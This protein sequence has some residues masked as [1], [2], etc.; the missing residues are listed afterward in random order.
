[1]VDATRSPPPGRELAAPGRDGR[2]VVRLDASTPFSRREAHAQA[3]GVK[4]P[5]PA[6]E[7]PGRARSRIRTREIVASII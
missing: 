4:R 1:M 2:A 3:E 7:R 6:R 5:Q